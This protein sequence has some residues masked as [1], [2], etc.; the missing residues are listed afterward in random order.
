MCGN[1]QNTSVSWREKL[2]DHVMF[3]TTH[4]HPGDFFLLADHQSGRC[5]V[6]RRWSNCWEAGPC[7][8]IQMCVPG[9]TGSS[10]WTPCIW[11]IPQTS[12]T[13]FAWLEE[14]EEE[15][16]RTLSVTAEIGG[17]TS[18]KHKMIVS[19]LTFVRQQ[20]LFGHHNC[21]YTELK[22]L[23]S[24]WP[25]HFLC[26]SVTFS[27]AS[28]LATNLSLSLSPAGTTGAYAFVSVRAK[29]A[30]C[31]NICCPQTTVSAVTRCTTLPPLTRLVNLISVNQ[32]FCRLLIRCVFHLLL[33]NEPEE[34]TGGQSA[35]AQGVTLVQVLDFSSPGGGG[36]A[37]LHL[38]LHANITQPLNATLLIMGDYSLV[39]K[40]YNPCVILRGACARDWFFFFL[41]LCFSAGL[42]IH[43]DIVWKQ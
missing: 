31:D 23:R 6:M 39:C 15:K 29:L 36:L 10:L 18:A 16:E 9:W 43:Q 26:P 40:I 28:G 35:L 5:C 37:F 42:N 19:M 32:T 13:C 4:R 2:W 14:E 34:A 38:A 25:L 30:L 7:P 12:W 3:P 21:F 27:P 17:S 24:E 8:G 20:R 33:V 41:C 22:H 11:G 1:F